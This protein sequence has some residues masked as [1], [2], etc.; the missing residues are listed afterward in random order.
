MA[1]SIF[2]TPRT[3]SSISARSSRESRARTAP[4]PAALPTE[5][6]PSTG[7]LRHQ[8]EHHR[9]HRVDVRAERAGQTDVADRRVAGVL[10]EQLDARPQ[11]R[12]G[13]LDR[14][15]VV[16]RD[17][18]A[19]IIVQHVGERPPIGDDPSSTCGQLAA[20]GA[21]GVDDPRRDHLGD[22]VDDPRSAHAGHAGAAADH[23]DLR[24]QRVR[25]DAHAL[26]GA[27]RRP[28]AAADLG[29]LERRTGRAR[30]GEHPGAV[31]EHDLGVR[32][33]VDEQ[34]HRLAAVR[35]LGEDRRRGVGADVPGDARPGVGEGVRQVE[36]EVGRP[37][38]DGLVGGQ[39]E[40]RLAERRRVDAEERCGA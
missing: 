27:G 38:R 23:A 30:R 26:D 18:Q 37:A 10:D 39:H 28:L 3:V 9:P 5:R 12:L 13:E 36:V 24:L 29:A 31:A 15:H 6:T 35:T 1:V 40:R 19:R 2:V 21:V 17:H 11:R 16:L 4:A 20:D 33:D 8:A 32:P 14:A 25:V 34:L 22:G 7:V